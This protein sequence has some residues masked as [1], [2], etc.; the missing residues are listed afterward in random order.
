MI[1]HI[2]FTTAFSGAN[3]SEVS[4]PPHLTSSWSSAFIPF[5]AYKT[6][7]NFS[8][9]SE[10]MTGTDFPICSSFLPTI[11]EGQ[12][13]YNLDLKMQ[14]DQGKANELLLVLDYNEDRSLQLSSNTNNAAESSNTKLNLDIAVENL[15]GVS[16]KVKINI[17]SQSFSFGG[18]IHKMSVVKRMSAKEDFLK[19]P[20]KDRN[21]FVE[22]YEDCR[23]RRLLEKCKCVP[24]EFPWVQVS[25]CN[26]PV[27]KLQIF[28]QQ[29]QAICDAKGRDC[30]EENFSR[31][32]Y[33]NSTCTGIYA[34][35][36][37]VE[38]QMQDIANGVDPEYQDVEGELKGLLGKK[39]YKKLYR[40]VKSDLKKESGEEVDKMKF[41][42]LIADY[43]NLKRNIVQHFKFNPASQETSFSKFLLAMYVNRIHLLPQGMKFIQLSS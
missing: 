4:H 42:K 17:L 33:C 12:L 31:S 15:Q 3:P 22:L 8:K 7:L 2:I 32:F 9:E 34:D 23:T 1:L 41:K 38:S 25:F 14:S 37:K 39:M 26:H 11:M 24:W 27:Q 28:F 6:D 16:A 10:A 18:G 36:Q 19:M 35:V 13:C 5:C 40:K 30:I 20:L 21:C 29:D 43:K